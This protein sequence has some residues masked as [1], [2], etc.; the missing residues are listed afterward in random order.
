MTPDAITRL[1]AILITVL[2]ALA[3]GAAGGSYVTFRYMDAQLEAK[4]LQ[5]ADLAGKID[6]QN[7]AIDQLQADAK[8]RAD[9]AAAA[10]A[11]AQA[12]AASL[13][14]Q[15]GDLLKVQKPAGTDACTAASNLI[16]LE[17]SK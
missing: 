6:V 17:L 16:D 9:A 12:R 2:V 1:E 10:L 14:K 13:V 11:A 8:S 3:V 4:R 15:A 7:K 5:V